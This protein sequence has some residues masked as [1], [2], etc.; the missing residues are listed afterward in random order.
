MQQNQG[1][2]QF[3]KMTILIALAERVDKY[4]KMIKNKH[5]GALHDYAQLMLEDC[6]NARAEVAKML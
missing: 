4:E 5:L 6:K 2:T 3:S 1:L